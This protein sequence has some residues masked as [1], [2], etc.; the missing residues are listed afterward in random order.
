M[1]ARP[2]QLPVIDTER[3]RLRA[4]H[5]GDVEALFAIYGNAEVMR[6]ASEPQ[7]DEPATVLAML[8]SVERLLADGSSLEWGVEQRSD[9][10]LVGTCGLHSFTADAAS[11]EVG[12]L[13]ARASWGQ[14]LMREALA[15]LCGYARH[16]LQLVSLRADIDALNTH[17]IRLFEALGF[18][19]AGGGFYERSL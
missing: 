12:C 16:E 15:A 18:R 6:F 5:G 3:L 8:Q 13:L 19:E 14:G 1:G 2:T 11:A 10:K 9:Q 7:F 17:S 4:L